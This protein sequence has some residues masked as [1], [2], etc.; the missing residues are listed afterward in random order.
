MPTAWWVNQGSTYAQEMKGEYVWAPTKTKAGHP[1]EHHVN[2][3][4]L[5]PGDAIIHY[6]DGA[7]RAIGFVR[8]TPGLQLRPPELPGHV[9]ADEGHAAKVEY[10][11]LNDPIRIDEVQGRTPDGGPFDR[12]GT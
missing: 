5:Q 4:R 10:H 6:A 3:S 8:G 1:V 12:N 11:P 7:I 9:W 2:V